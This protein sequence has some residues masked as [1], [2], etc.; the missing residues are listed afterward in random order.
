MPSPPIG[1]WC[2]VVIRSA[3]GHGRIRI[4]QAIAQKTS[5]AATTSA[6]SVV[7]R[8]HM[9]PLPAFSE[10]P[11]TSTPFPSMTSLHRTTDRDG[12]DAVSRPFR[13]K[14]QCRLDARPPRPAVS[15][16]RGIAVCLM[17][18]WA[19]S[20]CSFRRVRY[21]RKRRP[22]A[23]GSARP[24]CGGPNASH[25]RVR[26]RHGVELHQARQDWPTSRPLSRN[27]GNRCRRATNTL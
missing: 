25:V 4:R 2:H 12:S 8:C 13:A 5:T 7:M 15:S 21:G 16:L 27:F 18:G 3:G 23:R 22:R 1:R 26:C 20:C 10:T 17:R 6:I 19:C 9:S 14:I 11:T 24:T